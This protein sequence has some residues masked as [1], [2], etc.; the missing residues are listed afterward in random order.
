MTDDT[1]HRELRP[2]ARYEWEQIIMRAR[3]GGLVPARN[4]RGAVTAPTYRLVAL[5]WA[6]HADP[7][8]GNI[9]PG[10]ATVAV[11][12]EVSVR[13]V[14]A[15]K[16][17]MIDLG[18]MERVRPG[19]RRHRRGDTFRLTLPT[20]LLDRVEVLSPAA[21]R[22]AAMGE[23]RK[24][25]GSR[26]GHTGPTTTPVVGGTPGPQ[27]PVETEVCGGH[28]GP[29]TPVYGGHTGPHMGGT[30]DR[31]TNPDPPVTNSPTL[32]GDE[33]RTAVTVTREREAA[34]E[35]DSGDEVE[36]EQPPPRPAGCAD[37]GP[38]FAAGN[39]DDGKPACPLC[40]A[41]AAPRPRYDQ[42]TNVI[43]MRPRRAS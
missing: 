36:P 10:D 23:Y 18:L 9:W 27:Q 2:V 19:A 40:R 1:Q 6:T 7:D 11:E 14:Q 4:G 12:A 41:T 30:P 29:T 3:L 42:D 15:V 20:D 35:P 13:V 43:P 33:V 16:A 31:D 24:R 5:T 8:G 26:G 38:R 39:R 28:T 17:S 25:R 34:N 22:A 32:P 21:V 37:H